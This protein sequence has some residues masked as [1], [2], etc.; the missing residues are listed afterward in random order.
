[1]L[2]HIHLLTDNS[3]PQTACTQYCHLILIVLPF[4]KFCCR[5]SVLTAV[6]LKF[7][8]QQAVTDRKGNRRIAVLSVVPRP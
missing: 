7:T 3:N 6:K 2:R 5:H 1:M 8:V 4:N